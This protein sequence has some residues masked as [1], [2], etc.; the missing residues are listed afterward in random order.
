MPTKRITKKVKVKR[1]MAGLGLFAEEPIK[2]GDFIIEYIGPIISNAE[3]D[4]IQGK[5]LFEISDRRVIDGRHRYN[6]ARYINHS[7][8][9][10]ADPNVQRGKVNIYAT[11]NIKPGEEITYNY[12]NEYFDF[13]L[14]KH[15]RCPK[16]IERRKLRRRIP[17]KLKVKK[18]PT[19]LGLFAG[20]PIKKG[21]FIIEYT[22]PIITSDE[23]DEIRGLYLFEL[24]SKRA[25]DGRGRDNLARYVNHSCRPN[26]E[27]EIIGSRVFLFAIRNIKEGEEIAYHYGKEYFDHFLADKCKC[28]KCL[29]K[30]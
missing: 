1:S 17:K 3:A 13:F 23:A 14:K 29:E 2:K 4:K 7:C 9:P 21:S 22:G 20:E 28:P 24:S 16:C 10:N 15:C 30:K 11:K 19:G 12:G 18:S 25:I 26:A 6:V 27:T 8:A 5:Y